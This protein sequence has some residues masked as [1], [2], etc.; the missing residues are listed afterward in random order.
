MLYRRAVRPLLFGVAGRDP[1]AIH[2]RALKGS[3]YCHVAGGY[4]DR[5][6]VQ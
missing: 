2:E 1:E 4:T 5:L 3:M 6:S